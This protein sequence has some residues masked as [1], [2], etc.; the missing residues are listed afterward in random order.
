MSPRLVTAISVITLIVSIVTLVVL[1]NMRDGL[2]NPAD[3]K[4][5]PIKIFIEWC[6]DTSIAGSIR[7]TTTP[8]GSK[9][10]ECLKNGSTIATTP[11]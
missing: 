5:T 7:Y 1:F 8:T 3:A 9:Q 4:L 2:T 10:A 11:L 6:E